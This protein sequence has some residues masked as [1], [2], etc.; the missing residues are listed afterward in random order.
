MVHAILDASRRILERDGIESFTTNH[1]ANAAGVSVG[2]LYQ[3][4]RNKDALLLGLVERGLF[5][6][7]EAARKSDAV[8]AAT[9]FEEALSAQLR[10]LIGHLQ[11]RRGSLRELLGGTP[12]LSE[13]GFMATVE[14]MVLEC[15]GRLESTHGRL[16]AQ[17]AA[18]FVTVNAMAFTFL[19]WLTQ[20]PSHV[21]EEEFVHSMVQLVVSLQQPASARAS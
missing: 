14:G 7:D 2:S 21:S 3:Y 4:F 5:E 1:V 17:P 20:P 16:P 15:L 11:P 13:T 12:L 10:A 9:S 18:R 19:R 8:T 6:A